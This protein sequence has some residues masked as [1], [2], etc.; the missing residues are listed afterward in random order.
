MMTLEELEEALE[1]IFPNGFEI[2]VDDNGQLVIYTGLSQNDD[3][4]LVEFNSEEYEDDDE[5]L[6]DDEDMESL[7]EDDEDDED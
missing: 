5:E 2:D 3:G 7:D 4:E 1:E 6:E